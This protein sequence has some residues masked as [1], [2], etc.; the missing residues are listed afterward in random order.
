MKNFIKYANDFNESAILGFLNRSLICRLVKNSNLK[1][2]SNAKKLQKKLHKKEKLYNLLCC[3][4]LKNI[5]HNFWIM[6]LHVKSVAIRHSI[7][8]SSNHH[9]LSR[10]KEVYRPLFTNFL[11]HSF[12][13]KCLIK[14]KIIWHL[15]K[16]GNSSFYWVSFKSHLPSSVSR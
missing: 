5:L 14:L 12:Y 4:K 16:R 13:E 15:Y 8:L 10:V 7:Y 2:C 11:L 6:C 3:K 9:Y 1:R